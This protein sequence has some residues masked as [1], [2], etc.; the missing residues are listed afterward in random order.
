MLKRVL[1]ASE[2]SVSPAH[3]VHAV[4]KPTTGRLRRISSSSTVAGTCGATP[5]A[6]AK[7]QSRLHLITLPA[8]SPALSPSPAPKA[9]ALHTSPAAKPPQA[10]SSPLLAL[11]YTPSLPQP[12]PPSIILSSASPVRVFRASRWNF[13]ALRDLLSSCQQLQDMIAAGS[14]SSSSDA[15]PQQSIIGT[16]CRMLSSSLRRVS[17]QTVEALTSAPGAWHLSCDAGV[18]ITEFGYAD[19][20]T[21]DSHEADAGKCLEL[22]LHEPCSRSVV[23]CFQR[24][25]VDQPW[26]P[27]G[28]ISAAC[29]DIRHQMQSAP[30][31]RQL[32]DVCALMTAKP[33]A[34]AHACELALAQGLSLSGLASILQAAADGLA[35]IPALLHAQWTDQ[36]QQAPGLPHARCTAGVA[37]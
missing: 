33:V 35:T 31:V 2:L 34:A 12:S 26:M 17:K 5:P 22:E 36:L 37:C 24:S 16:T 20:W 30:P 4:H 14:S 15:D 3:N 8:A 11:S 6:K 13:S 23:Q 29:S 1:S 27:V 25:A 19:A 9:E 28:V 18:T 21:L 32:A 7:A 10:R